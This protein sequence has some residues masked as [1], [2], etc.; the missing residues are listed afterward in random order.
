[1]FHCNIR[2]TLKEVDKEINFRSYFFFSPLKMVVLQVKNIT[3]MNF[4]HVIACFFFITI[5]NKEEKETLDKDLEIGIRI[6]LVNFL[7]I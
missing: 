2:F 6:K 4:I 7:C 3:N 1:M 5:R